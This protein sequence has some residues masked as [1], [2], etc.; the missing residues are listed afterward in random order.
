MPADDVIAADGSQTL[1]FHQATRRA[2]ELVELRRM[3]V[4]AEAMGPAVTVRTAI[5]QYIVAREQRETNH[6]RVTED[7]GDGRSLRA[8]RSRSRLTD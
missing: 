6:T 2:R 5:D 1:S 4:T 7:A 3:E 8:G